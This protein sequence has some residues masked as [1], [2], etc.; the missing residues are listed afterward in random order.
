MNIKL[1][2]PQKGAFFIFLNIKHLNYLF[3]FFQ[4]T[5][6]KGPKVPIITT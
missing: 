2:A 4:T 5:L 1:K 3:S 6:T